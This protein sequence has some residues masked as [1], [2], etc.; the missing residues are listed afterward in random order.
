MI[1]LFAAS[2]LLL[3]PIIS[4]L[5]GCRKES[6]YKLIGDKMYNFFL[7]LQFMLECFLRHS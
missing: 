1:A 4:K 6:K 3:F 7:I 2:H 5:R